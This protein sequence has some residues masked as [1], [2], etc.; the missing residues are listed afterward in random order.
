MTSI[1]KFSAN[2]YSEDQYAGLSEAEYDEAMAAFAADD[3]SDGDQ[4]EGYGEWSQ[5]VE[6]L[7]V[8]ADGRVHHKPEPKSQGRLNGVEL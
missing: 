2:V 3:M 5:D 8:A 7:Y 6:N 4:W 1:D